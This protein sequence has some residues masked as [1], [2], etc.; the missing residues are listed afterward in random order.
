[1]YHVVT[2]ELQQ[3]ID[4]LLDPP[5]PLNSEK[6]RRQKVDEYMVNNT[7]SDPQ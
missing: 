5:L 6:K 3:E 2:S 4:L 1:M 7:H